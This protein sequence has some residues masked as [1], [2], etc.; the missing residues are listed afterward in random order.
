MKLPTQVGSGEAAGD[1]AYYV[2]QGAGLPP[3]L[4]R[5]SLQAVII[6]VSSAEQASPVALD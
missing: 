3:N 6:L 4:V 5:Y 2:S 1:W